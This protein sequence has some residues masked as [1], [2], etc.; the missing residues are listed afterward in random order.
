MLS[1]LSVGRVVSD[2]VAITASGCRRLTSTARKLFV[3]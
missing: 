3:V 2:T 1:V